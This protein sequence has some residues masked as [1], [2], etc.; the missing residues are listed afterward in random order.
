MGSPVSVVIVDLVMEHVE[1]QALSTFTA[2]P[3]PPP[4]TC[5]S[6]MLTIQTRV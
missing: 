6:D 1:V 2:S 4:P 3:P 5:G